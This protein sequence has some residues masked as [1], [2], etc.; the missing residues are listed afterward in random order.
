[1]SAQRKN[2]VLDTS[3]VHLCFRLELV[4]YTL[5]RIWK[6]EFKHTLIESFRKHVENLREATITALRIDQD[7][8][9]EKKRYY[10]LAAAS[11]D[12]IEF[13]LELMVTNQLNIISNRHYSQIALI[14]DEIGNSID[15]LTHALDKQ[16]KDYKEVAA[17]QS[18]D[19][20]GDQLL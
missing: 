3:I 2:K 20:A 11:L 15:K 17:P 6:K 1:M 16:I 18:C 13:M 12:N 19:N 7:N 9:A 8:P 4:A 5:M 10:N 14:L